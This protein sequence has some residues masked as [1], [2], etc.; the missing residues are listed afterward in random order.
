MKLYIGR[1]AYAGASSADPKKERDRPLTPEGRAMAKA[2]ANAMA[3]AGEIPRVIFSSPFQRAIETSDIYG[4]TW[5]VQVNVVGEMA[6]VRPLTNSIADLLQAPEKLKRVLL[7]GHVD[8]TTPAMRELEDGDKWKPL[9]MGEVRRV[10][11]SRS[12]LC[13]TL[14]WQIRPSDLGLKDYDQ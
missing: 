13:W 5:G 12:D 2:I 4:K 9:V 6:P 8:N 10:T 11:M 3:A 7:V 14:K 1:H